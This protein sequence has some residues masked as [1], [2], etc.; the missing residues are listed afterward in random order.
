MTMFFVT[1]NSHKSEEI[2]R[3]V[4]LTSQHWDVHLPTMMAGMVTDSLRGNIQ[5]RTAVFFKPYQQ[6][7]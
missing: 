5:L 3:S 7:T 2:P 4:L 6:I 1:S